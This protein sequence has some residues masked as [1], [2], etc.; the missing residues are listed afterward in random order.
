VPLPSQAEVRWS[1]LKVGSIVLVSMILLTTLLFL[2]TSAAGIAFFQKRIIVKSYFDNASGLKAG[3]PVDLEGVTIGEVA[4]VEITTDPARKLTPV[5]IVMKLSPHFR[6]SLHKDSVVSLISSGVLG[7]TVVDINSQTATGPEIQNGDELRTKDVPSIQDVVASSQA[8]VKSVNEIM[9]KIND[10]VT[11][12]DTGKGSAGKLINDPQL[13]NRAVDTIGQ[14]QALA[15]NL[16]KGRGTAGKLLTD[17]TVYNNL[18]DT[19]ARLDALAT[20][21]ST[22]KGSAGKLLTDDT[23]YNNLNTTLNQT[24]AMLAQ[25]NSGKG[26]LG[27]LIKDQ[28]FADRLNDTVSKLDLLLTNVD[29]GKGTIGKLATDDTAYT[30]LNKLLANTDQLMTMIRQDPKKY[31]TIHMKIF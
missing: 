26:G 14:L 9:P 12:I 6:A 15:T 18:K 7:D 17:D 10:I 8:T 30:N 3:A 19:T 2:M 4:H 28:A 20:G 22:G 13:Y 11:S 27:L 25:I 21:L 24:N 5:E 31:L 1:K 23:L 29:E 16:N